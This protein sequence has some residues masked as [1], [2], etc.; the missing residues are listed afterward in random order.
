M[1][2]YWFSGYNIFA[3][4]IY[5]QFLTSS[6]LNLP[7]NITS[8][9]IYSCSLIVAMGLISML[10]IIYNYYVHTDNVS[11]VFKQFT[12]P[13]LNIFIPALIY[14]TIV[15]CN[16][17]ALSQVGGIAISIVNL[18]CILTL[19]F[20]LWLYQYKPDPLVI[21]YLCIGVFFIGYGVY[22]HNKNASGIGKPRVINRF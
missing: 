4:A 1:K 21:T 14:V 10:V 16:V 17:E 20:G 9:V 15:Y 6:Q 7:N 11:A 18:N 12:F 19:L 5:Y 2:W 8:K 3:F 13:Y 22:L